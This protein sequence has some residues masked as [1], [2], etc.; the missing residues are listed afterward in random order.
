M[1]TWVVTRALVVAS[2]MM[3]ARASTVGVN[4]QK[5][6]MEERVEL[7]RGLRTSLY[8]W[9]PALDSYVPLE[10]VVPRTVANA[11]LWRSE[12]DS[13]LREQI[14]MSMAGA[15]REANPCPFAPL[16]SLQDVTH[17]GVK[18]VTVCKMKYLEGYGATINV[19]TDLK[20]FVQ[21]DTGS[22]TLAIRGSGCSDLQSGRRR[23]K[24][25]D[26]PCY[27][28]PFYNV[29]VSGQVSNC[30]SICAKCEYAC[31]PSNASEGLPPDQCAFE[32]SYGDGSAIGGPLV[33]DVQVA[34]GSPHISVKMAV[35]SIVKQKGFFDQ[36]GVYDGIMG[37][38]Y[39]SL[40]CQPYFC[41]ASMQTCRPTFVDLYSEKQGFASSFAMQLTQTG[42]FMHLGPWKDK[43]MATAVL[44]QTFYSVNLTAVYVDDKVIKGGVGTF[45]QSIVDSGTTGLLVPPAVYE[46]LKTAFDAITPNLTG[47]CKNV[48]MSLLSKLPTVTFTFPSL[49]AQGQQFNFTCTPNNYLRFI[50]SFQIVCLD[51]S[52]SFSQKQTILGDFFMRGGIFAFSQQRAA[53]GP[54]VCMT[55]S[56]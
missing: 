31:L 30:K 7:K 10:P 22:S 36:F 19:G 3:L 56:K 5:Q 11:W 29:S 54:S 15:L 18:N 51:V 46:M 35:G 25:T 39:S 41:P 13:F 6:E 44:S 17:G 16:K 1:M 26:F 50:P 2:M 48:S 47:N 8:A 24:S 52:S 28:P 45:G 53:P 55:Q 33:Y 40:N 14:G 4:E 38:A 37:L 34:L 12:H 20:F 23:E 42:G 32:L 49:K 27:G 9:V 43:C 21:L